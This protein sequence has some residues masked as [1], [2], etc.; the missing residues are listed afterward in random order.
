MIIDD[1]TRLN[2]RVLLL[3][4]ASSIF[5]N[6]TLHNF[7]PGIF[8]SLLLQTYQLQNICIFHKL[9]IFVGDIHGTMRILASEDS[10]VSI[11]MKRRPMLCFGSS[12]RML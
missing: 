7:L 5:R 6:H 3:F 10:H 4:P 8:S 11:R 1:S 12:T 9:Y 2:T